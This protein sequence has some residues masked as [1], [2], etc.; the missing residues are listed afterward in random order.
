MSVIDTATNTVTGTIS[1]GIGIAPR[2]VVV[3]PDGSKVYITN[4]GSASVSVIDTATNTVTATIPVGFAP[5]GVAVSP[6]GRRIYV[7]SDL[8]PGAVWVIDTTMDT[9]IATIPVG[10]GPFGVAVTPDGSKIFVANEFSSSVS[11]IDAA[12][13]AATATIS[14]GGDPIAFGVFIQP[15]KPAP[16]FAGTPGK[17]NCHGKSVSA[18]AKQYGGLNSAAAA[19][20]FSSVSA[21]QEAIM[22]FCGG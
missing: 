15:P 4:A 8:L 3:T 17:A 22:A 14:V 5:N 7:V 1:S 13:S 16:R 12:T 9:V 11:V 10:D 2:G 20:G 6:H 18:L 21:L 19:L